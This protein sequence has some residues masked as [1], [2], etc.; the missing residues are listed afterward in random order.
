MPVR[1][2]FQ[3]AGDRCRDFDAQAIQSITGGNSDQ[4]SE[5]HSEDD[6]LRRS[7]K[8]HAKMPLASVA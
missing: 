4:H 8:K 7:A 5:I 1:H 6:P 2:R 3:P